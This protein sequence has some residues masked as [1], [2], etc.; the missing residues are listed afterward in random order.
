MAVVEVRETHVAADVRD[1]PAGVGACFV[2]IPCRRRAHELR[3][4]CRIGW[5]SVVAR[6]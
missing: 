4:L 1:R 5:L 3:L 2:F 6:R